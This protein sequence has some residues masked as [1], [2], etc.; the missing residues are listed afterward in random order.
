MPMKLLMSGSVESRAM[1]LEEVINKAGNMKV[2]PS[3]AQKVIQMMERDDV[4]GNQLAEA[5]SK[6]LALSADLLKAASDPRCLPTKRFGITEKM[7]WTP[8]PFRR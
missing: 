1:K 4:S 2:L 5:I 8:T 6:G 7:L 3:A